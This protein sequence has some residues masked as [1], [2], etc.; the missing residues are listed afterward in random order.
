MAAFEKIK[1]GIPAMDDALHCIRLG[2]NVVWQVSSLDEFRA[3]AVPFVEQAI[4]DGR[5]LLYIRF[6]EHEPILPEMEGL[7]VVHVP[8]SHGSRLLLSRSTTSSKKRVSTLLC[9]DCLSELEAAGR[10]IF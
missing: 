4:R 2:D 9:F 3:V 1:S 10:Q 6:A 5:N 7:R 8:L